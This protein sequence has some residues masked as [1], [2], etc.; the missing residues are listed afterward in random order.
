VL[1]TPAPVGTVTLL[2][3]SLN[4]SVLGQALTFTASVA[5]TGAF[6]QIPAGTVSFLD[7]TS[8]LGTATLDATGSAQYT[9]SSLALGEHKITVSYAGTSAFAA[10][11]SATL[12]QVVVASLTSAGNGFLL[13][14]TPA[15]LAV[16]VGNYVSVSVNVLPLNGFS[17]P[18]QLSCISAP[19]EMR[20]LFDSVLIPSGGGTTRLTVNPAAP[21]DCGSETPYFRSAGMAELFPLLAGL[22]ALLFG[23]R[24]RLLKGIVLA[25]LLALLP[26]LGG[27]GHCTDLGIKPG[28]YTF[29]VQ[30]ASMGST[31]VTHAVGMSMNVHL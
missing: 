12:L 17:E 16:G 27:C 22:A 8:V 14:V 26:M 10:N 9:T 21:H 19:A 4:P 29:S 30:G 5:T 25:C 18:V 1:P 24:K 13:T 3:S 11:V 31:A 15:N 23:R 6:V 2:T 7:G 28:N 20:C